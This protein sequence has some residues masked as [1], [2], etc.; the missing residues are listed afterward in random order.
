[1]SEWF[2]CEV[3]EKFYFGNVFDVDTGYCHYCAGM[4]V[5]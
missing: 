3:C 2:E 5:S 4:L 1:M